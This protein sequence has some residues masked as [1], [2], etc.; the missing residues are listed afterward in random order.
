MAGYGVPETDIARVV[1]IDPKTLR[2]HCRDELETGHVKANS[3]VAESLYK[4][5]IGNGAGSVTA[6]I[7][8]MKTRAGWKETSVH[9]HSGADG[10]P[11]QTMD[12]SHLT[13]EQLAALNAAL[14]GAADVSSGDE[15]DRPAGDREA[16]G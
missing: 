15:A 10:G 6:A 16:E 4:K 2:K 1:G 12:V 14:G 8:W 11:I 3:R 13:D 9:Q 7:F 5:A